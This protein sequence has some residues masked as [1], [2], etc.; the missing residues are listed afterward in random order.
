MITYDTL[1]LDSI[2]GV[3]SVWD[4]VS[5]HYYNLEK[6]TLPNIT[7]RARKLL[8]LVFTNDITM[9]E[10]RY[11]SDVSIPELYFYNLD[12]EKWTPIEKFQADYPNI[13]KIVQTEFN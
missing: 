8:D 13:T 11:I 9:P 6:I 7:P 4:R 12:T 2:F 1:A 5:I 10:M 3:L